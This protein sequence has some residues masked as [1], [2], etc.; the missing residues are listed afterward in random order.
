MKN[1]FYI[2]LIACTIIFVECDTEDELRDELINGYNINDVDPNPGTADFSNYV[3][4]GASYTAGYMDGAIYDA[5]QRNSYPAII[6]KQLEL[7]GGGSFA[8][9]DINSHDGYNT[10]VSNPAAGIILGRFVLDASAGAPAPIGPGDLNSILTPYTGALNNFGVPGARVVDLVSPLYGTPDLDG[11]GFPEGNPFY[12]RIASAPG[13]SS[14]LGDAVAANAS[15]FSLQIGGNDVLGWALSG[16]T[17]PDVADDPAAIANTAAL[18]DI[19]HF[20]GALDAV[21]GGLRANNAKGVISTIGDLTLLP[22]FSLVPYNAI[23]LDSVS[24]AALNTGFIGF[25][26]ILDALVANSLLAADDAAQRKISYAEG[27]NPILIEDD[28]LENLSAKFDIL[29]SVGAIT[30]EQKAALLPFAIARPIRSSEITLVTASTVLGTE[31]IPGNPAIIWGVSFPIKDNLTLTDDELTKLHDRVNAFNDIIRSHAVSGEVGIVDLAAFSS[32]VVANGGVNIN[33]VTLGL[34]IT[35]NDIFST[36][37]VHPNP[38]GMAIF[39]NEFIKKMNSEFGASI[40]LAD[41]LSLPG[42]SFL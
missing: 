38:R 9:P 29:E 11:D 36:D 6:A 17:Q 42:V 26:A 3:A 23:P 20:T 10:V 1:I 5:G 8:Q 4:V 13:T 19:P 41:V 18:T 21:V 37:F 27:A 24:A 30:A 22:M 31:V 25:N 28:N 39:A 40:P 32:T 7:A 35:P 14:I 34:S 15:F 16:G 33:G 12:V 2:I